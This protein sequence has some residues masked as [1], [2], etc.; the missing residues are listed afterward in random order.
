MPEAQASRIS[1]ATERWFRENNIP[2]QGAIMGRKVIEELL[3]I[4]D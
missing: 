2:E 4:P 1:E 3:E